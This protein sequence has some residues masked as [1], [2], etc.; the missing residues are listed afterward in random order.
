M[1]LYFHCVDLVCL[2]KHLK[3]LTGLEIC[4]PRCRGPK[5]SAG[6][7]DQGFVDFCRMVGNQ[8]Q[9]PHICPLYLTDGGFVQASEY[10]QDI[11]DLHTE[12][13][14]SASCLLEATKSFRG[15]KSLR[16]GISDCMTEEMLTCLW[17]SLPNL[18]RLKLDGGS[19]PGNSFQQRC[20]FVLLDIMT[21][22]CMKHRCG[23]K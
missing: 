10:L 1:F 21:C 15:L 4:W 12:G 9:Q 3:Y 13:V 16:V 23:L 6:I 19:I 11:I 22:V 18:T 7:T 8:M 2:G 20:R 5:K 14:I 17:K